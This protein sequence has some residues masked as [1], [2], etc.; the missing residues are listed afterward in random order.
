[1]SE[2]AK[3]DVAPASVST[4]RELVARARL[5][6]PKFAARAE[7]AE[8]A[9]QIPRESVKEMLDAGFARILMPPRYGGYD[10]DFETWCEVVLELSK[11]DASHG[12]CASLMIH[13]AHLIAQFPEECQQA[14][15]GNGPDVAIA[16]SFAPRAKIT[17]VDGGYRLSGDQSS[18]AS[19]V[20]HSSWVMVGGLD[21]TGAAPEW[22]LLMVPPGAYSVRDTWFTAG[23]R[24]TGSCT[25]I[26]D[27]VFVPATRALSLPAL[28]EG[29]GPGGAIHSSPIYRTPFFFYAPITF[30]TPMLGAA[31]GAYQHFRE[32]TKPRKAIDGSAVA[33]KTSIQV[34]MARAAADLDAAELLLRRACR[35][36]PTLDAA[37]PE[38]L[39]RSIRDF[40][41][42]SELAVEA[43]DTL[44][45]LCGTAGFSTSHPIQR[46]WRDIHFSSM[47]ISV[48][49]EVNY[50][51]FG[52]V[53]LGL[54]RDI[55]RPFF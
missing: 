19:G 25:I 18:F 40:T 51:H 15:W 5:L 45:A 53:E 4:S 42:V 41:R 10:L 54:G 49:P 33:E 9:R 22:L 34:R 23:M 46:A 37:T 6:A 38:L 52:R 26:T 8:E 48:N 24:G 44:I 50:A 29:K 35:Q 20:N 27:D 1:M 43:I 55:S 32:W 11:A 39:A 12:W 7:M 14:I 36:P 31:F 16:A 30:A 13:H 21:T 47:H 17:R 28:R 2:A 3:V